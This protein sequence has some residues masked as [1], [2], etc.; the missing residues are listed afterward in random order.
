MFSNACIRH[1]GWRGGD[2]GG[3]GTLA[4]LLRF[5]LFLQQL[6]LHSCSDLGLL[7][8]LKVHLFQQKGVSPRPGSGSLSAPLPGTQQ[9]LRGTFAE[10]GVNR[11][12]CQSLRK[13][14]VLGKQKSEWSQELQ[15]LCQQKVLHSN[16]SQRSRDNVSSFPPRPGRRKA[17]ALGG[18]ALKVG[19]PGSHPS[20][21]SQ[22]ENQ[23]WWLPFR[24]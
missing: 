19:F 17:V 6:R 15:R 20:R 10:L 7:A 21:R 3:G 22:L 18:L 8:A 9:A 13:S 5:T 24:T 4:H 16:W 23:P 2:A 14:C 1:R 12:Q 11:T